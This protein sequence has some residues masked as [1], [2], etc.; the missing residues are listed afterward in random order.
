VLEPALKEQAAVEISSGVEFASVAQ[1]EN[2]LVTTDLSPDEQAEILDASEAAQLGAMSKGMILLSFIL[3]F[4][5]F[6]TRRLPTKPLI[7][8]EAE[9]TG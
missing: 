9:R 8:P 4:A 1:V 6:V 7:P 3:V 2:A 5:L